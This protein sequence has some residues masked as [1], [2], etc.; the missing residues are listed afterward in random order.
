MHYFRKT[1]GSSG[2]FVHYLR[3]EGK[4]LVGDFDLSKWFYLKASDSS[5]I[6]VMLF[7]FLVWAGC[8]WNSVIFPLTTQIERHPFWTNLFITYTQS[9]CTNRF[10]SFLRLDTL[11]SEQTNSFTLTFH[12]VFEQTKNLSMATTGFRRGWGEYTGGWID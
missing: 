11:Y 6:R 3:W 1:Y 8:I 4:M 2:I 7:V 9:C 10:L 5:V 12:A